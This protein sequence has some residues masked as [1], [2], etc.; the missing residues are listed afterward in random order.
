MPAGKSRFATATFQHCTSSGH[1]DRWPPVGPSSVPRSGRTPLI[2]YALRISGTKLQSSLRN[3]RMRR[4]PIAPLARAAITRH[5]QSGKLWSRVEGLTARR[6]PTGMSCALLCW[7]LSPTSQTGTIPT[8]RSTS[9]PVAP[10]LRPLTKLW[11]ERPGR[12][13]L[14]E[15][16]LPEEDL[17][18]LKPCVSAQTRLLVTSTPYPFC[19]IKSS[20][21]TYQ[22]TGGGSV[23]KSANGVTG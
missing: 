21:N 14:S 11:A 12:D 10:S 19:S 13:R 9:I 18:L 15:T 17:S 2:R 4:S 7:T 16:R 20:W 3:S 22:D 5:G 8:Y 6:K 23:M 1:A